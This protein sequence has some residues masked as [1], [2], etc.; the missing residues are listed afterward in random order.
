MYSIDSSPS[1]SNILITTPSQT[2]NNN[3]NK[4]QLDS[5]PNTPNKPF[6]DNHRNK[7]TRVIE[8]FI[9]DRILTLGLTFRLYSLSVT[10]VLS[11]F[12]CGMSTCKKKTKHHILINEMTKTRVPQ[13]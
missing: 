3:N 11:L 5:T 10:G 9:K 13:L 2:T 12:V 1:K 4:I 8:L 6:L 7:V